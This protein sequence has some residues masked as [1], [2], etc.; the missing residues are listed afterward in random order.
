LTARRVDHL[1]KLHQFH[2]I[3]VWII[4]MEYP[5]GQGIEYRP[6]LEAGRAHLECVLTLHACPFVS[7]VL[8]FPLRYCCHCCCCCYTVHNMLILFIMTSRMQRF[9]AL[10]PEYYFRTSAPSLG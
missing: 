7:F 9:V 3:E 8:L 10:T 4:R 6:P 1:L 5:R 2:F